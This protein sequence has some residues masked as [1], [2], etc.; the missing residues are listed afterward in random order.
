M[1]ILLV[2]DETLIR[3]IMRES[4]EEAGFEVLDVGSARDAIAVINA[5]LRTF[6]VLVTDLHLSSTQNGL[7]V[8][9]AMRRRFPEVPVILATG[10][11]DLLS[12]EDASFTLLPKPY[13]IRELLDLVEHVTK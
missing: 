10:R 2:E 6:S 11:P 9:A 5:H 1:C 7:D 13:G 4:L 3:G 8:A 12:R